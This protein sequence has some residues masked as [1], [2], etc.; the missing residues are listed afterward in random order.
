MH[1]NIRYL[2]LLLSCFLAGLSRCKSGILTCLHS[3]QSALLAL[4]TEAFGQQFIEYCCLISICIYY[5]NSAL[6]IFIILRHTI[7]FLALFLVLVL[8]I[9]IDRAHSLL[10][11]HVEMRLSILVYI[12]RPAWNF[13]FFCLSRV[14]IVLHKAIIPIGLLI[15]LTWL[16]NQ[17]LC[18]QIRGIFRRHWN[19][20]SVSV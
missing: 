10:I 3:P 14:R 12:S 16:C 13:G 1:L 20:I 17:V 11:I 2:L 4:D 5:S 15:R 6:C 19:Y 7:S 8:C 18:I 9:S